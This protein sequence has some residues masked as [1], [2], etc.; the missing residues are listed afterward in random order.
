MTLNPHSWQAK[1]AAKRADTLDKIRPEWRLAASD[2]ADAE[3]QRDLTGPFIQKFLEADEIS[4]ISKDSVKIV[5]EIKTGKL[6]AV[7]ATRAF[8]K[9]AAIAHQIVSNYS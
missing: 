7:Q 9:T 3:K 2:L 8:C 5:E 6:T 1:A 4:I